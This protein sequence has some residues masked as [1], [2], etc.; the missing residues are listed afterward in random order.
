[1]F[2][3]KLGNIRV[4]REF[5]S[6]LILDLLFGYCDVSGKIPMDTQVPSLATLNKCLMSN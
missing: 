3:L 5:S 1:M 4:A 6:V 2:R